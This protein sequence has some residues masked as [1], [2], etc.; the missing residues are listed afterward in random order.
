MV[1]ALFQ[2]DECGTVEAAL[3]TFLLRN[4]GKSQGRFVLGAFAVGV[5]FSITGR[6]DLGAAPITFA[7]LTARMRIDVD[8][9]RLDP[10][11]APFGGTVD[12]V[13]GGIFLVFLVPFHFEAQ[14]EEFLNVF[15]RYMVLSAAF[16][17]HMLG[18]GHRQGENPAEARM[19]HTV[20]ARQFGRFR[21]RNIGR[22]TREA[23]DSVSTVSDHTTAIHVSK[24]SLFFRD[25]FGG[26][27]RP[28]NGP[29]KGRGA[30]ILFRT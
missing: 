4:L 28:E 3:P 12:A 13:F 16:G 30:L 27:R 22:Q 5:P 1:T 26:F 9:C 29:K 8:I 18:I 21:D 6:A 19:A 20:F 2:L 15:E 7:V 24:D 14:V 11:A 17:R 10:F 25:W 23:L